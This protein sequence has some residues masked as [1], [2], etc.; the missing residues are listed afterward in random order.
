MGCDV[1]QEVADA[2]G[3]A[4]GPKANSYGFEYYFSLE[5]EECYLDMQGIEWPSSSAREE[6][7]ASSTT[8]HCN[9]NDALRCAQEWGL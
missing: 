1:V 8:P 3:R 4:E 6:Y 2:L 5:N 7:Q 9:G